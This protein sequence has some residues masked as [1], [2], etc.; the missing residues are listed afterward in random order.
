MGFRTVVML[1]NDHC[2]E[3][4]KDPKLGEKIATAMNY[5]SDLPEYRERARLGSYGQVVE[6][7]H[8]DTIT[9]A[10][11]DGYTSFHPLGYSGCSYG[12]TTDKHVVDAMKHA[13]AKIG[14]RLVK[15][16]TPKAKS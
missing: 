5:A 16:P 10:V 1:S 6:C 2:H 9:V 3:W 15:L 8:A 12:P 4:S 14:Y 13:A 11:L 7:C